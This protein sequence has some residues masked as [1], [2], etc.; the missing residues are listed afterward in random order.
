MEVQQYMLRCEDFFQRIGSSIQHLYVQNEFTDVTLACDGQL[1]KA[2][3]MILSACSPYFHKILQEIPCQHP[4]IFLRNINQ[5]DM[6]DL[7]S[8]I[9]HGEVNIYINNLN[10]FLKT[11]KDLQIQ[12]L[13]EVKNDS[14]E[15]IDENLTEETKKSLEI[16]ENLEEVVLKKKSGK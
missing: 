2:H 6:K 14:S 9:Y 10:S 7:I 3:K 4:V 16:I 8:Y 1:F 5:Q 12:G 13:S 15:M 11:G